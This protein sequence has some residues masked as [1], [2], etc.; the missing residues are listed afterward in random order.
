MKCPNSACKNTLTCGCQVIRAK[1]GTKCCVKCVKEYN[2]SI[3][4]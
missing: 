3:K 4:K 1:D 2:E